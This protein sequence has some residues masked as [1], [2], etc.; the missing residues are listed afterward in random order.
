MAS[1]PTNLQFERADFADREA[2]TTACRFCKR[3]ITDSYFEVNGQMACAACREVI[4]R[5]LAKTA[6][7]RG[8]FLAIGAGLGAGLVGALLYYAVLALSGYEF[9]LISIAV[10]YLVGRAVRWASGGRGGRVYQVIAVLITYVAIAGSHA[11]IILSE[12]KKDIK[13]EMQKEAESQAKASAATGQTSNSA[14]K[15]DTPAPGSSSNAPSN[16]P[17]SP[18]TSQTSIQTSTAP[19]ARPSLPGLVIGIVVIALLLLAVP[20]LGGSQNIIGLIIIGVALWEA[21]RVTRRVRITVHGPFT[22]TGPGT[23]PASATMG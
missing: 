2:A 5:E 7:T 3:A 12:I 15:P 13:K 14:S 10:G 11:P 6:G 1:D 19:V 17:S 21:Y 4:A 23:A 18:Q 16:A 9:A 20:L 8:V 22:L